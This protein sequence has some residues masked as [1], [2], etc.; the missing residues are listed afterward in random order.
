M[1]QLINE[2]QYINLVCTIDENYV[3]HCAV[4]LMSLV[5][6]TTWRRL[7]VFIV[8]NGIRHQQANKLS[9]FLKKLGYIVAL[10]EIDSSCLSK[11]PVNHHITLATYY[12]LL[13][14]ELLEHTIKKIIFLD[15]DL[16]IREDIS[17]LWQID[18]DHYSHAAV[19]DFGI[20]SEYKDRLGLLKETRYFNAGVLLINLEYW[21]N[22]NIRKLAL[23]FINSFPE[24]ITYW[25][26]DALN[27][28]LQEKW[29]PL[30]PQWNVTTVNFH[31]TF[32]SE[33][34]TLQGKESEPSIIHFAGGGAYKP[35]HYYCT[36]PYKNE[37]YH[38]L[39]KTPWRRFIPIGKPTLLSRIK[40]RA[41]HLLKIHNPG[42]TY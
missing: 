40:S 11:A 42:V 23:D 32:Q 34:S 12:R 36:H 29:Y 14:P 6:N 3:Q 2:E 31:P 30:A 38:Y 17:R 9:N 18:V 7:R 10:I 21:R 5:S 37:Y 33:K 25:D 4:M 16:I 24:K 28:A 19:E 39:S 27:Y 1:T 20:D 41:K 13:L 26:Q 22:H 8:H 15:V 35:W